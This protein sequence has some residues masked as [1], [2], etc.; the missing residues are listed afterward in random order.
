M[1]SPTELYLQVVKMVLRYLKGTIILELSY[2]KGGNEELISYTNGGYAGDQDNN[3]KNQQKK[4]KNSTSGYL[5]MMSSGTVS[6]SS[7]KTI[8]I[9]WYM[10]K[11]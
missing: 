8:L 5:F 2:K 9:P 6:W 1:E 7:K 10:V 11:E 3:K 4:K